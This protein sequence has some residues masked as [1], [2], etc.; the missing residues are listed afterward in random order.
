MA[1]I[2]VPVNGEGE[3]IINLDFVTKIQSDKGENT[4]NFFGVNGE[5]IATVELSLETITNKIAPI[6]TTTDN[7]GNAL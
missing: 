4:C 1:F 6:L 7:A 2:K 3:K 5:L